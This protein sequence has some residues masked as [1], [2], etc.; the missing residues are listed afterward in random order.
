MK[1]YDLIIYTNNGKAQYNAITSLL[2]VNPVT[3]FI[4]ELSADPYAVWTYRKEIGEF[5]ND[6]HTIT[7]LLAIIESKFDQLAEIG[8]QKTDIIIWLLYEYRHQCAMEFHPDE[9]MKLAQLGI[10]LNIDC[11]ESKTD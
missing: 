8:I 4:D 11:W 2:E 3:E 5:D 9:M 7:N 1:Y 10:S 6:E